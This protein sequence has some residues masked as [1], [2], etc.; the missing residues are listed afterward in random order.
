[1]NHS[2]SHPNFV[3]YGSAEK[4][5]EDKAM[6]SAFRKAHG[7]NPDPFGAITGSSQQVEHQ[8]ALLSSFKRKL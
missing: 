8:M 1:M 6:V 2:P 3:F 7:M 5:A 4:I